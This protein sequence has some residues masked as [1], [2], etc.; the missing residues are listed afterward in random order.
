MNITNKLFLQ[1]NASNQLEAMV[2]AIDDKKWKYIFTLNFNKKCKV[3]RDQWVTGRDIENKIRSLVQVEGPPKNLLLVLKF[4]T[5]QDNQLHVHGLIGGKIQLAETTFIDSLS[6][7][8]FVDQFTKPLKV[9]SNHFQLYFDAEARSRLEMGRDWIPYIFK[10]SDV[11]S[12]CQTNYYISKGVYFLIKNNNIEIER[13]ESGDI[14]FAEISVWRT[15]KFRDL[16]S[17]KFKMRFLEYRLE[18]LFKDDEEAA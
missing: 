3:I 7:K 9:T 16:L 18:Q 17:S 12:S 11:N 10:E 14:P 4:E 5:T 15:E 8:T 2:R 6:S 13:M 1:Q